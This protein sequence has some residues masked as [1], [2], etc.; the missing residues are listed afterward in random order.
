MQYYT[1]MAEI[2]RLFI[3]DIHKCSEEL[4]RLKTNKDLYNT[5]LEYTEE[6]I[7]YIYE[8]RYMICLLLDEIFQNSAY[9]YDFILKINKAIK[10]QTEED[11]KSLNSIERFF[12]WLKENKEQLEIKIELLENKL[13]KQKVLIP[14]AK[15][16]IMCIERKIPLKWFNQRSFYEAKDIFK[17]MEV[18]GYITDKELIVFLHGLDL[19]NRSIY[20]E[21]S[22]NE[23]EKNRFNQLFEEIPN[24]LYAGFQELPEVEV[25]EKTKKILNNVASSMYPQLCLETDIISIIETYEKMEYN[26]NE[27]KYIITTVLNKLMDDL[28]TISLLI[29]D[30]N[31]YK[32]KSQRKQ[33]VDEYYGILDIFSVIY[34]YYEKLTKEEDE[35]E[36]EEEHETT[37]TPSELPTNDLRLIYSSNS[38]IPS[39]CK[40]LVDLQKNVLEEYYEKVFEILSQFKEGK[41]STKKVKN[42]ERSTY[43]LKYDQIRILFRHVKDNIYCILGVSVKKKNHDGNMIKNLTSRE[44]P[45]ISTDISLLSQLQYA[46]KVEEELSKIV[47][48]RARKGSRY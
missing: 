2:L 30:F 14:V 39:K 32:N 25:S 9:S 45:N 21:I 15:K 16:I 46:E 26:P 11:A 36:K 24:I 35:E 17:Y 33:I 47:E 22:E 37:D 41:I 38:P 5:L 8:N 42:I 10:E 31:N 7:D 19:Y 23:Q 29:K 20:T 18:S 13:E 12:K 40:F 3:E 43:E 27:F 48:T 4:E 34:N 44:V 1:K 28:S 6:S